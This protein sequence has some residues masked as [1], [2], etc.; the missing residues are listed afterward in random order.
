MQTYIST[1]PDDENDDTTYGKAVNFVLRPET[2]QKEEKTKI[3][4]YS[5]YLKLSSSHPVPP[6]DK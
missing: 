6:E 1:E 4:F 5:K 3:Q 2:L